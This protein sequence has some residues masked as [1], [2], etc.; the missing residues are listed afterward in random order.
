M[1][2]YPKGHDLF[3]VLSLSLSPLSLSLSLSLSLCVC[4][5]RKKK[6]CV[7]IDR[8]S[9]TVTMIMSRMIMVIDVVWIDTIYPLRRKEE[10]S[11][12]A[13]LNCPPLF[14]RVWFRA[15]HTRLSSL[16]RE[17]IQVSC[18]SVQGCALVYVTG[19]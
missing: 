5:M 1:A 19:R 8:L 11:G 13:A 2:R 18:R 14:E 9:I 10:T 17:M 7:L 15:R 6:L 4:E 12:G 3:L 16:R